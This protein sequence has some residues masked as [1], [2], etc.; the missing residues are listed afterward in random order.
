MVVYYAKDGLQGGHYAKD[1]LPRS[2]AHSGCI[3]SRV[4]LL[5]SH[6]STSLPKVLVVRWFVLRYP[7][8]TAFLSR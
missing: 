7:L 3:V 1:V 5:T 2:L 4:H 6:F 8:P